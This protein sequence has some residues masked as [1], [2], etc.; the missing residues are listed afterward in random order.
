MAVC[1]PLRLLLMPPSCFIRRRCK[2]HT[3]VASTQRS[4]CLPN[5]DLMI[6]PSSFAIS[7][8]CERAKRMEMS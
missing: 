1:M 8:K 3:G 6:S 5:M 2:Q 4:N 7:M